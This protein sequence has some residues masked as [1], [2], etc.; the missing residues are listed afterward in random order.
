MVKKKINSCNEEKS[1][2]CSS[3]AIFNQIC[4]FTAS[5]IGQKAKDA[6]YN[7]RNSE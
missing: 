3:P 1:F 2:R 5:V 4:F 6:Q 7:K